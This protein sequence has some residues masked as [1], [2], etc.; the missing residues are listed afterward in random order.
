MQEIRIHSL[1]GQGAV[2]LIRMLA[3]AGHKSGKFVQAFPFFGAERRGAPVKSYLRLDENPI[4]LRSQIYEPD[5]LVMM[6]RSLIEVGMREGIK[7]ETV[8][9]INDN[10]VEEKEDAK[11]LGKTM[12][13]IDAISIAL[14]LELETEGMP[15]INLVFIGSIVRLTDIAPMET[16]MDVIR[17]SFPESVQDKSMSCALSGFKNVRTVDV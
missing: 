6:D 11:R 15:L 16:V 1:G 17:E 9:L 5:L 12:H 2:T 3:Q 13:A 14:D 7:N 8:C 4:Y 10:E